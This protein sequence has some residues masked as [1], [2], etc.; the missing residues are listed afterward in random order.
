MKSIYRDYYKL[1]FDKIYWSKLVSLYVD[2]EGLYKCCC[3]HKSPLDCKN[4]LSVNEYQK[5][6]DIMN[7]ENLLL[8]GDVDLPIYETGWIRVDQCGK[9][10]ANMVWKIQREL[11]KKAG[12]KLLKSDFM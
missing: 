4:Q 6:Q 3:C 8:G 7:K 12:F 1:P 11:S 9:T 2:S 10:I 5:I